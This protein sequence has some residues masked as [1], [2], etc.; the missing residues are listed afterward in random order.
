M[1]SIVFDLDVRRNAIHVL[2]VTLIQW[3]FPCLNGRSQAIG[4]GMTIVAAS[5]AGKSYRLR[6]LCTSLPLLANSG[7]RSGDGRS[8]AAAPTKSEVLLSRATFE[9]AGQL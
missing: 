3:R 7:S 8:S 4:H 5:G 2:G 6:A 9:D 1:T